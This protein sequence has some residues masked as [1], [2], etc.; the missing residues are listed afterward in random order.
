MAIVFED[1]L[2]KSI[3]RDKLLPVYILF[4]ED[5][6]LKKNYSDKIL[7]LI[8]EPDD[9]FNCSKFGSDCELQDVY[10]AV[11]QL[12]FMVSDPYLLPF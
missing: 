8:T 9:V 2:K 5:G 12:P 11:L 1:T 6:Y 4:G 10:D 7:K 3:S